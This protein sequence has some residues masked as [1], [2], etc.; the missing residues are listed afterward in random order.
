M[1]TSPLVS[2]EQVRPLRRK[3]P[4]KVRQGLFLTFRQPGLDQ[5]SED[6][7]TRAIFDCGLQIP[8]SKR[9]R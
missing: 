6:I 3:R 5:M 1:D 7:R 8:L 2:L 4:G 9:N